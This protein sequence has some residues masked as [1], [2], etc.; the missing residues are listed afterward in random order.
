[1]S[2]IKTCKVKYNN[3]YL[4]KE[5]MKMDNILTTKELCE[6]LKFSRVTISNWRKQ[7]MPCIKVN[8][9]VRFNEIEVMKWL[10]EQ[11]K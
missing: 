5:V 8:R 9:A 2:S 4:Y 6:K 10:N 11:K 1:M 3:I 7:G